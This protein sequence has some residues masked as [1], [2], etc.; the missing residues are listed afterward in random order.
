MAPSTLN[1][2]SKTTKTIAKSAPKTIAKPST[3]K[4]AS[5][6]KTSRKLITR[7]GSTTADITPKNAR[8]LNG[9]DMTGITRKSSAP[10]GK[11]RLIRTSSVISD[12]S[13]GNNA[14]FENLNGKP[15]SKKNKPKQTI[16]RIGKSGSVNKKPRFCNASFHYNRCDVPFYQNILKREFNSIITKFTRAELAEGFDVPGLSHLS[17]SHKR[18]LAQLMASAPKVTN[19]AFLIKKANAKK[20]PYLLRERGTHNFIQSYI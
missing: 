8:K 10:Q 7:A 5:L 12:A 17:H 18:E 15:S 4:P 2:P 11:N 14:D 3:K 20:M 9:G 13:N 19:E 6:E 1:T 16:G